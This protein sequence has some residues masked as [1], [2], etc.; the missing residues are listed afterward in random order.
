MRKGFTLI[1]V[2][3]SI[4][5][6]G[7]ILVALTQ[8]V[9]IGIRH[10]AYLEHKKTASEL[11]QSKLNELQVLPT[12]Q[13]GDGSHSETQLISPITYTVSWEIS[14]TSSP[15]G[16]DIQV[17]VQWQENGRVHSVTLSTWKRD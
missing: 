4:V 3:I 9:I 16:K 7:I 6:L 5:I 14:S 11:A 2:L 1:E 13:L 12:S 8:G 17:T 10:Q 15:S